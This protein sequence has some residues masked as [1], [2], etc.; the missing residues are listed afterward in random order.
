MILDATHGN[1]K[2]A[3]PIS[4]WRIGKIRTKTGSNQQVINTAP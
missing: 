4:I 2:I 3:Q 1:A